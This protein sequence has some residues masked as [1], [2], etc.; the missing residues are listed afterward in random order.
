MVRL[1]QMFIIV[2][3]SL[4]WQLKTQCH[5][6]TNYSVNYL[7]SHATASIVAT[8][9]V[10]NTQGLL[11]TCMQEHVSYHS[12]YISVLRIDTHLSQPGQ[13]KTWVC[14]SSSICVS[15]Y[16]VCWLLVYQLLSCVVSGLKE[17][18][19]WIIEKRKSTSRWE[20]CIRLV[21][22]FFLH[23]G[24]YIACKLRP[25]TIFVLCTLTIWLYDQNCHTIFMGPIDSGTNLFYIHCVTFRV[26]IMLAQNICA[27]RVMASLMDHIT[28]PSSIA[29]KLG[30]PTRWE[31]HS[32]KTVGST[33]MA[34]I[35]GMQGRTTLTT[36]SATWTCSPMKGLLWY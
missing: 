20:E 17:T 16:P 33:L 15:L 27:F 8:I 11:V 2:Q 28:T 19:L 22:F 21:F 23:V 32:M 29:S 7:R 12:S 18:A 26:S 14:L 24:G 35:Q 1:V 4:L 30:K 10:Y 6:D 13:D 5:C 3:L 34:L 36:L 9:L 25:L 31:S